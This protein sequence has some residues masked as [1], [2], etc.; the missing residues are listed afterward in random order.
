M[1][2]RA[3]VKRQCFENLDRWSRFLSSALLVRSNFQAAQ[4]AISVDPDPTS[5]LGATRPGPTLCA[6]TKHTDQS[7]HGHS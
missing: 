6:V 5:H 2:F 4:V 1:I 7:A 3:L